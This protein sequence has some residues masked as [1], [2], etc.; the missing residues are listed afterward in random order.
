MLAQVI[1]LAG[2]VLILGAFIAAQAGRLHTSS[3][4]YLLLNTVGSAVLGVLAAV[5]AQLGFLL[6]EGVWAVVSALGL[7]A[8]LRGKRPVAPGH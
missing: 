6:L 5:E 4:P 2:S 7:V 3:A 8:V 1:Q